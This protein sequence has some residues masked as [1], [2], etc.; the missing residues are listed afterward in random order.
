M[1]RHT[2]TRRQRLQVICVFLVIFGAAMFL[3]SPHPTRA[4][5][6]FRLALMLAGVAGM[7]WLNAK[8]GR[9]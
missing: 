1:T 8:K 6:L 5:I 2:P 7:A 9:G 3:V 4:Q